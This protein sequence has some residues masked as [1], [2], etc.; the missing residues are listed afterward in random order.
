MIKIQK[1]IFFKVDMRCSYALVLIKWNGTRAMGGNDI[2][3]LKLNLQT[4]TSTCSTVS[5]SGEYRTHRSRL[6]HISTS[7]DHSP[8]PLCTRKNDDALVTSS[9]EQMCQIKFRSHKYPADADE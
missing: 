1:Y 8:W 6:A 2:L 9:V 7:F 3:Y 4:C 5:P